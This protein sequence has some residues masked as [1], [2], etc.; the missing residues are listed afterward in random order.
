MTGLYRVFDAATPPGQAPSGCQ[1]VL[2]YIGGARAENVWTLA[3]W[4]RFARLAQ[5][6]A[7]V[8]DVT[9]EKPADAA[10]KAC[11]LAAAL[12]WAPWQQAK[13]AIICDLE[14]DIVRGWY[15]QFAAEVEQQGFTSVAYGSLSTVLE[16]AASEVW[17]AAWDGSATLLPGQ[18]V[19]AHQ[20][21]AGA[22]DGKVL[23]DFSVMD[24]W[25]FDR[26]GQGPRHT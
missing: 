18:T 23:V 13:R 24:A 2:G 6:P 19:H 25:L 5:F 26:G 17:V 4:Q 15:A 22:P 11:T 20:Y 8:P 3:E 12:G 21:A 14:T 9:A 7:Y 10:L 1:G 16:N